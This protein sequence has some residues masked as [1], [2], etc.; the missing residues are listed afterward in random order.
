VVGSRRTAEELG[1]AFPNVPVISSGGE[2]VLARV[3]AAPALVVA[4]TGAEPVAEGGYA[5]ALLLDGWLLL[6]RADLRAG[7]EAL[8]R[9]STAASLVQPASQGGTVVLMATASARPAQALVRWDPYGHAERE[10]AERREV[11]LPPAVRLATVTGDPAGVRELTA[12][13]ELPA[14]GAP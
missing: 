4:T 10:L 8:R 2:H 5:A 6:A 14:S 7:E 13:L 1:R 12:S 11:G 9:W 3:G